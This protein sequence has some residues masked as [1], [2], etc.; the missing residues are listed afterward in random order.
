VGTTATL[1]IERNER[2]GM[3]EGR[4]GRLYPTTILTWDLVDTATCS[5]VDE[6]KTKREAKAA[7]AARRLAEATSARLMAQGQA[8]DLTTRPGLVAQAPP[9]DRG[10]LYRLQCF[11]RDLPVAGDAAMQEAFALRARTMTP[12]AL[13]TLLQASAAVCAVLQAE[14]DRRNP[15][16]PTTCQGCGRTA[17]ERH[18][19]DPLYHGRCQACRQA[20]AEIRYQEQGGRR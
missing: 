19:G 5:L 3:T 14:S 9:S 20:E 13:A 11:F 16:A 18:R 17:G 1:V 15:E 7:L 10:A 4:N 2:D 12:A 8:A 6:Y